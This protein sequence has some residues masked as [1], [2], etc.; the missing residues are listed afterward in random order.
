MLEYTVPDSDNVDS[1]T[2][3]KSPPVYR[4]RTAPTTTTTTSTTKSPD[5]DS[6]AEV[7]PQRESVRSNYERPKVK[8]QYEESSY[9]E[10]G[11]GGDVQYQHYY[12]TDEHDD[13]GDAP[14]A[15]TA[16]GE[17]LQVDQSYLTYG[18]RPTRVN[19]DS[20]WVVHN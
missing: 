6:F 10:K 1:V 13:V 15:L 12:H 7:A 19:P 14:L 8:Y 18:Q 11:A 9:Y 20:R 17:R 3:R 5:T 16:A 2:R 4:A